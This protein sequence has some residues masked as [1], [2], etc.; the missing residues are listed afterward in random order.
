MGSSLSNLNDGTTANDF[1][2]G[3]SLGDIPE[4][5]IAAVFMHLTPPEICNLAG[6]NRSFR[7][8]ASSDS[9]WEKKLPPNYQALLDLLP[10]ERYLGLSK[11]DVFA[12]LSRPIPFD[13]DNKELWIDRVTGRVCMAVSARGMAITGIED[14]RYWNWIPTDESRFH[15]VAYLQQI[16]W[17]EVD[18]TVTFHLPPGIYS[19]SFRIHLG[20][21]MRKSG[22]RVCNYEHT[23]GWDLKPVRFSLSTSDG[24][25][26]SCEYYLDDVKREEAHGH[27]KRGFWIDYKVGEFGLTGSEP[28]TEIKWSMKQIDCTHSKGGLCVDSVF[29]NPI[30]D[31]KDYRTKSFCEIVD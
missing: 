26:A 21:F 4:S 8:A 17:F 31:L 12:V 29:I 22:R 28:S 25:E 18:G 2:I 11:K 10:P 6:L 20:G 27:H 19:L 1:S 7:G 30:G 14:R 16:W 3:P 9:V 24:Q 23:H 13:D 15:V 5:C